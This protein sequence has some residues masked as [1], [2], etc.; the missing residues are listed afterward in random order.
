ME[1]SW[2][3][4]RSAGQPLPPLVLTGPGTYPS[5]SLSLA[6]SLPGRD[7]PSALDLC[8]PARGLAYALGIRGPASGLAFL[9]CPDTQKERLNGHSRKATPRAGPRMLRA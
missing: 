8:G 6:P 3:R 1:G 7:L 5:F 2:R 4:S 9:E